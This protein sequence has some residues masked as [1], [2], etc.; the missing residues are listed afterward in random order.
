[1]LLHTLL[2][3]GRLTKQKKNAVMKYVKTYTWYKNL[4]CFKLGVIYASIARY[5][6]CNDAMVGTWGSS[7]VKEARQT[8][9]QWLTTVDT[10]ADTVL[11]II[12][13]GLG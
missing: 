8:E 1:M 10:M 11:C 3:N 12:A 2:V 4:V 9:I 13:L 5:E 7:S 6:V